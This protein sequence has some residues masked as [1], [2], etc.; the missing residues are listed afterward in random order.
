MEKEL[1]LEAF[2]KEISEKASSDFIDLTI[3]NVGK[4]KEEDK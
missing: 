1:N 4:A 3:E 2:E